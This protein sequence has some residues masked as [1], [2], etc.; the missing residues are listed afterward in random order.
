MIS[1]LKKHVCIVDM[2]LISVMFVLILSGCQ[3]NGT[4]KTSVIK[5]TNV[6]LADQ[7]DITDI[8]SGSSIICSYDNYIVYL[9]RAEDAS[10]PED[11]NKMYEQNMYRYDMENHKIEYITSLGKCFSSIN[12]AIYINNK[13]FYPCQNEKNHQ[14]LL[15]I[16]MK[17][18]RRKTIFSREKD[19][20]F[21]F[22]RKTDDVAILLSKSALSATETEYLIER[23]DARTGEVEEIVEEIAKDTDDGWSGEFISAMDV[24]DNIVY[25]YEVSKVN[26]DFVKCYTATGE[27]KNEYRVNDSDSFFEPKNQDSPEGFRD[28]LWSIIAD[29]GYIMLNTLNERHA[30]YKIEGNELQAVSIPDVLHAN[31]PGDYSYSADS[32]A[33]N[34]IYLAACYLDTDNLYVFDTE[35]NRFEIYTIPAGKKNNKM[36]IKITENGKLILQDINNT[37]NGNIYLLDTLSR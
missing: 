34:R 32:F 7:L 27:L 4:I 10:E 1:I 13:I 24:Y 14:Q 2:L 37:E 15:E 11:D 6:I 23:I 33:D 26:G 3:N 22:I 30:L 36:P 28:T 35:K 29:N 25:T 12:E 19:T 9:R 21:S 17:N 31:I 8:P 18:H 16:D 5:N 20:L